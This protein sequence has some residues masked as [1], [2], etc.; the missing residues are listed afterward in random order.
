[1]QVHD[2]SI[3]REIAQKEL[4]SLHKQVM[5][6]REFAHAA[7]SDA[8]KMRFRAQ[9]LARDI[10]S[11]KDQIAEYSDKSG[12]LERYK[13]KYKGKIKDL[14]NELEVVQA[15]REEAVQEKVQLELTSRT[16]RRQVA[17]EKDA[18]V[19]MEHNEHRTVVELDKVRNELHLA[20]A[21]LAN[22]ERDAAQFAESY[23]QTQHS[24]NKLQKRLA[25]EGETARIEAQLYIVR[26][27]LE[28]ARKRT[29]E[30]RA[31]AREREE[32][33]E[34]LEFDIRS[35]RYDLNQLGLKKARMERAQNQLQNL[36]NAQR[37]AEEDDDID[38]DDIELP[39]ERRRDRRDSSSDAG[40][41]IEVS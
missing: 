17:D 2:A 19:E 1:V 38:L 29:A 26:E 15:R 27:E 11:V 13:D 14:A 18:R 28:T 3:A 32:E 20:K 40:D 7:E 35:L 12:V 10:E 16:L 37:R 4:D 25:S 41:R 33:A 34:A 36:L 30:A 6:L 5:A 9:E 39:R 24:L 8:E 21:T 31:E 23:K 22:D